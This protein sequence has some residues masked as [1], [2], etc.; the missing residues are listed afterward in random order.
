MIN[1]L[2]QIVY[3]FTLG[4]KNFDIMISEQ[5]CVFNKRGL[6]YKPFVKQK[7]LK[8]YFVKASYNKSNIICTFHT[9]QA[10]IAFNC[11]FKK[12]MY[13]RNDFKWVPKTKPTNYLGPKAIWVSK[14]KNKS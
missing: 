10:H 8:N 2:T 12:Q 5:R 7:Y 3:K 6:R 4:E 14:V 9:K 13:F 1:D 11:N